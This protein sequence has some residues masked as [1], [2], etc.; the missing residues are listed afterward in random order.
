MIKLADIQFFGTL[1]LFYIKVARKEN[2]AFY[3]FITI[4]V[5]M[6]QNDVPTLQKLCQVLNLPGVNKMKKSQLL[7]A[8]DFNIKIIDGVVYYIGNGTLNLFV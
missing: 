6:K 8:I 7:E 3:Q 5:N 4:I 1:E 2:P